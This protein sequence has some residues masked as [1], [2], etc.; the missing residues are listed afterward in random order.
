MKKFIFSLVAMLMMAVAT[1]SAQSQSNYAGSSKFT[2]NVSV[3]LQGGVLT[4]FNDFY[5]GHTAMAPIVVIGVD[6]YVNPWFGVGIEGRTL[7]GTGNIG[8]SLFNTHTAFD[9]VNV[10]GLAKFNVVN[11]FD[12]NGNRRVFEP[13]VYTGLGWAHQTCSSAVKRNY[14]TY[15]S[16]LELNFNIGKDRA[17]AVVVNPSVVWGDINNGKLIKQHGNFEVTAG[18]VY[19]FKTSNGTRSFTKAHLYNAREV[20]ALNVRIAKLKNAVR[21]K[22]APAPVTNTTASVVE[23]VVRDTVFISPKVQFVSGTSRI[24]PTSMAT[25]KDI[26][27]YIK[28]NN[29]TYNVVG[30]ASVEGD[31]AYN[32]KLSEARANA[33]KS[34]LV[35]VGVDAARLIA[36]GKGE[37]EQFGSELEDNRV[38]IVENK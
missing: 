33:V 6:K 36:I 2:D 35:N 24:A 20:T 27:S 5:A 37:T 25:I 15:R 34:A 17:W 30:F 22:V 8:E 31:E 3:T 21:T 7:I 18:V 19:H 26:A 14:M 23:K 38:V 32:Q 12:F 29:K 9:N 16:G 1:V 28:S 10:S 11:L 13:V 4:T